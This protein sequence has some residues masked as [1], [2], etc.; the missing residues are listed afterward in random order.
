MQSFW[1]AQQIQ[2]NRPYQEDFFAVV[3]N[4]AVFYQGQKYALED[5][6]FPTQQTLY[7]L[8]DG[9][10]GMGHGDI[11]AAQV[12]ESFIEHYL[13]QL[14]LDSSIPEKLNAA[15][16]ISNDLL[17]E[18]VRKQPEY[19]GMGCTL[20]AV[21]WDRYEKTIHWLSIGDSPLW[22]YRQGQ[23]TR[24]NVKHTW[25]EFAKNRKAQNFNMNDAS[26]ASIADALISAVDGQQLVHIDLPTEAYPIQSGDLLLLAS[27]GV[28]TLSCTQIEQQLSSFNNYQGDNAE[29]FEALNEQRL[30]LIKAI[31]S[32]NDPHQDN[33][34]LILGAFINGQ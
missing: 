4:N 7:L 1:T 25:G 3:E 31:E 12:T 10:G 33:A 28:E 15:L 9:M 26:F 22:L 29:V 21:I 27:D 30:A 14:N 6:I 19:K 20:I 2:G 32:Q 18:A 24:L 16:H 8:T 17:A 5:G 13:L 11:A 34:S 23:L